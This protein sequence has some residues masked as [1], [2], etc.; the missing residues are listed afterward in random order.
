MP[1]QQQLISRLKTQS[2]TK[3]AAQKPVPMPASFTKPKKKG[4]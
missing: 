3:R 4:K 1:T 2:N